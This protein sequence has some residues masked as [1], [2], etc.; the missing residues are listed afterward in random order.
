MVH[1]S[2]H[3]RVMA[4]GVVFHG[5]AGGVGTDGAAEGGQG[6]VQKA[7]WKLLDGRLVEAHDQQG[8]G[9]VG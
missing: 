7:L 8:Q 5:R 4:C 2:L 9:A 1:A 6:R 3:E